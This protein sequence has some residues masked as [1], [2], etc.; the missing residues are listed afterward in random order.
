MNERLDLCF[1][2][3]LDGERF[4][5]A[6]LPSPVDVSAASSNELALAW[7]KQW[8]PGQEL[9]IRFL[10]GDAPLREKVEEIAR[11]WLHYADLRFV[12]GNLP[13]SDIDVT[14][15]GRG[16]S[17][18]VGTDA[19]RRTNRAEPSLKLGGFRGSMPEAEMR[20]T[21]LHEFGHAIG[22]IHEQ[23]SPGAAI[24]WNEAAVYKYFREWQGWDDATTY[25]NVLLRYTAS[26]TR[27]TSHDPTSIMQYP[28][29][30]ELTLNGFE[31]G[32]NDQLSP[33]D[34][35]FIA[36]MYPHRP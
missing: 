7:R 28:V 18:L 8:Q 24:P 34:K 13:D 11:E 20:R 17:S 2:A 16:Y 25:H 9:R 6:M 29:P 31:I 14:F 21:V 26:E 12:F 23:S 1:D 35:E 5:E 33:G 27:F 3:Y 22:C 4:D 32:W 15:Q 10:D 36:K 19:V 30:K